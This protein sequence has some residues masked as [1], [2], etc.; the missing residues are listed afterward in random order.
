MFH[1]CTLHFK[2]FSFTRKWNPLA[3]WSFCILL[4]QGVKTWLSNISW[5][6]PLSYYGVKCHSWWV[7]YSALKCWCLDFGS[8][9]SIVFDA[10]REIFCANEYDQEQDHVH[11]T[12][13]AL[14]K[15]PTTPFLQVSRNKILHNTPTNQ[16]HKALDR[17]MMFADFK[18]NL[19]T[20]L[21]MSGICSK[22]LVLTK[23][24]WVHY[25]AL[26]HPCQSLEERTS[27]FFRELENHPR[28]EL[29]LLAE[30]SATPL[31]LQNWVRIIIRPSILGHVQ[32]IPILFTPFISSQL[33]IGF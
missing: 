31:L 15:L 17:I 23:S 19:D 33:Q 12:N 32:W 6:S 10:A 11:P 4:Y 13:C 21:C 14:L 24:N 16:A 26:Q 20:E 1:D 25:K 3:N 18:T 2:I 9:N 28:V 27:T 5:Q 30:G 7:L 8:S 22:P 29:I